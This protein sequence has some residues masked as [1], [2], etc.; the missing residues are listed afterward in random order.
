MLRV[1]DILFANLDTE[2]SPQNGMLTVS[3]NQNGEV[4]VAQPGFSL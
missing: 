2:G 3:K 1:G 4:T